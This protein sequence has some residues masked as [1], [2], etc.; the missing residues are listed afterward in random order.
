MDAAASRLR[1][2]FV[3]DEPAVL[4][5]LR[6]L[7]RPLREEWDMAFATGGGE[8]LAMLEEAPFDAVVSDMRMPG[9]DGAE[10]LDEVKR[11][12]PHVVRVVL[13][14]QA[15]EAA[16]V[17]SLDATHLYLAKPC[18]P[19]VLRATLVRARA[20]RGVLTDPA[21]ARVVA[22]LGSLP[23]PPELYRRLIAE[24]QA[25]DS[26]VLR[27][28][29]IIAADVGMCAKMLHLVNSAFFGRR[30]RVSDPLQAVQLLGLD[31]VRALALSAHVFSAFTGT[32]PPGFAI[33]ALQAHSVATSLVAR[34]IARAEGWSG[35]VRADDASTAALLH[36]V[37]RLALATALSDR[38]ADVLELARAGKRTLCE[39][40]VQ[41]LGAT[42]AAVGAYLLGLWGLPEPVVEAV[43]YH[44]R[45]RACPGRELG[46]LAVVHVA[47][48][49]ATVPGVA[50]DPESEGLDL[51]YLAAVGADGRLAAWRAPDGAGRGEGPR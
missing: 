24:C 18:A 11:R 10:L 2:L 36:D 34:R 12:Q 38:Y 1:V 16:V 7:L 41:V 31:T 35:G 14:G 23:S 13:S 21:L 6:R 51:E 15:D 20:V 9:L 40:E 28:A 39:A 27:V 33:D 45:P 47:D 5:A 26:S 30:R 3:D 49:L 25:P 48:A 17:R 19:E 32:P 43:A 50:T 22:R 29:E 42:H 8:A 44:H 46:P 37:G 4:M